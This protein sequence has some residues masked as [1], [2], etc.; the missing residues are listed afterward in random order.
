[1]P[2]LWS[3]SRSKAAARQGGTTDDVWLLLAVDDDPRLSS[4]RVYLREADREAW[5][6]RPSVFLSEERLYTQSG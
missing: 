4:F 3:Q 6:S 2:A 1:M 5:I